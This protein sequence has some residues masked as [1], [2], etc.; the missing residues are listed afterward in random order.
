MATLEDRILGEKV[1]NYCS[2]SEDEREEEDSG[3]ESKLAIAGNGRSV[4]TTEEDFRKWGGTASNT[5]PKGVIQ[6][7]REFKQIQ[8]MED[9]Q[10]RAEA[11]EDMKK[12]S[13]AAKCQN[14][15]DKE[16]DELCSGLDVD[17]RGDPFLREYMEKQM[18]KMMKQLS[19]RPRFGEALTLS[20]GQELL[21]VIEE[22][23]DVTVIVHVFEENMEACTTMKRCIQCLAKERPFTKFCQIKAEAAGLS[24]RFYFII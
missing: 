1:E 11:L 5:G 23:N 21:T 19:A 17:L 22:H 14:D 7:W 15:A 20:D 16:L 10:K 13:F 24:R 2:S 12:R 8:K 3:S 9:E 4:E 18:N 6:D